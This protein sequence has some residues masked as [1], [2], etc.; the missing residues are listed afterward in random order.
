MYLWVPSTAVKES[1]EILKGN[2][3]AILATEMEESGFTRQVRK[4]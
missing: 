2:S 3:F 1:S 4:P